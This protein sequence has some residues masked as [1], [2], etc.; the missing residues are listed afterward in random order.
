M[1]SENLAFFSYICCTQHSLNNKDIIMKRLLLT[2]CLLLGVC[3]V[4]C[5]STTADNLI[6]KPKQ[7]KYLS[8]KRVKLKSV[9]IFTE[10]LDKWTEV[11]D[12]GQD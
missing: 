8:Q 5:A 9:D 4:A 11:D 3:A 1:P 2:I 12:L 6:P 10:D 7:I